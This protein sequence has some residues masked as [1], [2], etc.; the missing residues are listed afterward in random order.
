MQETDVQIR[1]FKLD[2]EDPDNQI[3]DGIDQ[4]DIFALI[5]DEWVVIK[6]IAND[7]GLIYL[8][9]KDGSHISFEKNNPDN[10]ETLHALE[11]IVQAFKEHID[12]YRG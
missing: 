1:G 5:D 9:R 3:I 12:Q 10:A 6:K 7:E 8:V 4:I 2:Y 11:R